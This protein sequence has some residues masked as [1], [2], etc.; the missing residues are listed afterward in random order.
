MSWEPLELDQKQTKD[1]LM[2]RIKRQEKRIYQL[3]KEKQEKDDT[4]AK[5]EKEVRSLKR[6]A[7]KAGGV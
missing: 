1:Q 7:K 6:T 4:I 2:R 5:L 3:E